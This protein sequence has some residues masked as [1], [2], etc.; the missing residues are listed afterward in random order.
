MKKV[1]NRMPA[2]ITP[3]D[4]DRFLSDEDAARQIC[5]PLDDSVKMEIEKADI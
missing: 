3:K 5:E 1:H 2:I 4:A